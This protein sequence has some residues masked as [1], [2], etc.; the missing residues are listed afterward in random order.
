MDITKVMKKMIAVYGVN[1]T[2]KAKELIVKG[3]M[4]GTVLQD[5]EAMAKALYQIAMNMDLKK[6]PLEET[7]VA[8]RIPY[9]IY[10]PESR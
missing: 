1:A 6:N 7:G 5:D 10:T 2:E 3:V 9:K 4:S 8:I